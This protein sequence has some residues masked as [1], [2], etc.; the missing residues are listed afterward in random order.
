MSE[1]DSVARALGEPVI[2][3][4]PDFALKLRRNLLISS[5]FALIFV[6]GQIRVERTTP[7]GIEVSGLSD[8]LISVSLCLLIFYHLIHFIWHSVDYIGI[9]RIHL[10]GTRLEFLTSAKWSTEDR[11]HPNDPK[12]SNLYRWWQERI[13]DIGDIHPITRRLEETAAQL[14]SA[15]EKHEPLKG[16]LDVNFFSK[17]ATTISEHASNLERR[18]SNMEKLLKSNRPSVSLERFDRWFANFKTSQ[19]I[20]LF[21][22][23]LGLP[24]MLGVVALGGIIIRIVENLPL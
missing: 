13:S 11:D 19:L 7:L 1:P 5:S 2:D 14:G 9:W 8:T 17:N 6:F 4:L 12:Q 23:E 15:A 24:C 10:T 3:E 22:L 21:L 18:L 20:R 16:G